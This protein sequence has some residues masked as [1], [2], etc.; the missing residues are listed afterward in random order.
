MLLQ[1]RSL[2]N[3][4]PKAIPAAKSYHD[5]VCQYTGEEAVAIELLF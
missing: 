1:L 2:P 3:I 5:V 4:S